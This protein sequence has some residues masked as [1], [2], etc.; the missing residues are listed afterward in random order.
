M[1][2]E[3]RPNQSFQ[4]KLQ[5]EHDPILRDKLSGLGRGVEQIGTTI[6]K[7]PDLSRLVGHAQAKWPH[8]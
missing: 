2:P 4:R 1:R 8:R 7:G 5:S 3:A 6:P